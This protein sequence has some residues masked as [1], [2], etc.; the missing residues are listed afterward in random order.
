MA[1]PKRVNAGSQSTS[2]GGKVSTGKGFAKSGKSSMATKAGGKGSG[3]GGVLN[4]GTAAA[5]ANRIG[6]TTVGPVKVGG[7]EVSVSGR[8][9]RTA[10]DRSV[11]V[12][13]GGRRATVAVQ[14]VKAGTTAKKLSLNASA[15][16]RDSH[17]RFA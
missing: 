7:A 6:G 13:V 2:K 15:Q 11:K 12:S 17:G 5:V 1:T 3:L 9:H 14:V 16:K 10:H 4:A 8:V